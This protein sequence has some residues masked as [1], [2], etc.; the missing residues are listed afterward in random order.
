[1]PVCHLGCECVG[2]VIT[3][4]LRPPTLTPSDPQLSDDNCYFHYPLGWT[5]LRGTRQEFSFFSFLFSFF[6]RAFVLFCCLFLS[7]CL[8]LCVRLLLFLFSYKRSF[9]NMPA[10]QTLCLRGPNFNFVLPSTWR[11]HFQCNILYWFCL[12]RISKLRVK[13]S[14]RWKIFSCHAFS[15]SVY[16]CPFLH[17]LPFLLLTCDYSWVCSLSLSLSL[18]LYLSSPYLKLKC[19]WCRCWSAS[20]AV[21]CCE[22]N[23]FC[24]RLWKTCSFRFAEPLWGPLQFFSFI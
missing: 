21:T 6:N 7:L 15:A 14:E 2:S 12:K 11:F 17:R 10:R 24:R 16:Y 4:L 8:C 5:G 22:R 23:G 13:T 3:P 19:V 1:M 20:C 9:T 18:S